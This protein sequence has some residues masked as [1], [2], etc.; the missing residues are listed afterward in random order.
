MK[1]ILAVAYMSK[2]KCWIRRLV[3]VSAFMVAGKWQITHICVSLC[4]PI[5]LQFILCKSHVV[6]LEPTGALQLHAGVTKHTPIRPTHMHFAPLWIM[7]AAVPLVICF[8]YFK[9]RFI[10][11]IYLHLQ[12]HTC[13]EYCNPLL[14]VIVGFYAGDF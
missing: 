13:C 2:T 8:N 9:L 12:R 4:N 10:S 3:A 11:I 5:P 1:A 6:I 7:S 14:C